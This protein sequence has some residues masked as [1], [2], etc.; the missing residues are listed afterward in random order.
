MSDPSDPDD[1]DTAEG[2]IAEERLAEL[3][4]RIEELRREVRPRRGPL[5]L[6]RPPTPGELLAFADEHALPTTI[7][8]LEANVRALEALREAIR[9]LR[10][11]ED[12]DLRGRTAELGDRADGL[13]E[14][15]DTLA[16]E[17]I[18]EFDRAVTDLAEAIEGGGLP[19]DARARSVLR[20][21]RAVRDEV[22]TALEAGVDGAD[23]NGAGETATGASEGDDG[24]TDAGGTEIDV[25]AELD[26]IREEIR[27]ESSAGGGDRGDGEDGDG[28]DES[29]T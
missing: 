3:E 9:L 4:T 23:E 24:E 1:E 27:G 20:E 13:R 14:R 18:T 12:R 17:A 16:R 21:A 10:R 5:G 28:D 26:S 19:D 8:V 6:P 29:E 2:P 11:V 15:T 22:T 7:A 25:E